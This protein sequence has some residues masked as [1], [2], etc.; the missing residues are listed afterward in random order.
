MQ[1]FVTRDFNRICQHTMNLDAIHND[2]K[3]GL[4]IS[5]F[6]E[7]FILKKDKAGWELGFG[8][9]NKNVSNGEY[10]NGFRDECK[11]MERR[12]LFMDVNVLN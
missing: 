9:N 10:A 5:N 1:I 11:T 2:W 4:L 8:R 12:A 3:Y 6:A 7:A